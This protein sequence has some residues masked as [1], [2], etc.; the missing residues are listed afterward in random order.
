LPAVIG[1]QNA[2]YKTM[3]GRG[4]G[5]EKLCLILKINGLQEANL[6]IWLIL[7][8]LLYGCKPYLYIEHE[9]LFHANPSNN[10]FRLASTSGR[11]SR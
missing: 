1:R 4:G 11:R 8:F 2:Q 9:T 7:T 5:K 3:L 10:L 6:I